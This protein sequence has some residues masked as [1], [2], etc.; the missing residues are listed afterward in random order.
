MKHLF[1]GAGVAGLAA[2]GTAKSMGAIVS[3]Y[4]VRPVARE[5]VES[6]GAKFLKVDFEEDGS[7]SGGYA[8]EMSDGYKAAE[9]PSL[10]VNS[11]YTS[12]MY[13]S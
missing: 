8:K 13:Y 2:I 1:T 5:Q 10:L 7:G 11:T 12:I 6:L 3:A 4:D 9:V